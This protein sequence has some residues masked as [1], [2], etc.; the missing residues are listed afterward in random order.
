MPSPL[1]ITEELDRAVREYRVRAETSREVVREGERRRTAALEV[2]LWATLARGAATLPGGPA[3]RE[4]VR[5]LVHLAEAAVAREGQPPDGEI[6]PSHQALYDSRQY[7]DCDELFV[8]IRLPL[9]FG[10]D[11]VEDDGRD[12][13]LRALRRRLDALGIFEV[14]WRPRP[15]T[16]DA[17][18]E[19]WSVQPAAVALAGRAGPSRRAA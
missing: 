19:P 15:V 1:S 9:R 5:S 14:R 2:R 4:A 16:P 13:R 17:A 18:A 11:G 6:E 12:A 3:C 7:P 8:A 10:E